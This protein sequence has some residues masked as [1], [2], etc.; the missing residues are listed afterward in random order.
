MMATKKLFG[1]KKA[2]PKTVKKA[3]LFGA[4]KAAPKKAPPKKKGGASKPGD[5]PQWY[6]SDRRLFLPGGL[7]EGGDYNPV[8]D[9][10]L[11]GDYGFDILNLATDKETLTKYRA[12]ELIHARWAMLGLVGVVVPEAIASAGVPLGESAVWYE[13]GKN[14]LDDGY[15]TWFGVKIPLPLPV[16]FALELALIAPAELY[17]GSQE[18]VIPGITLP[19]TGKADPL[20]PGKDF[21]FDPL[22]LG[23]DPFGL[24][25]GEDLAELKVKELKNG[26]LAMV[27]MLGVFVQAAV[28]HEGPYANWYKH[29]SNPFQYNLL[30]I[31]GNGSLADNQI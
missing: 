21:S 4:K 28:T 8:L 31:L 22:N 24:G 20:Y 18:N 6:G 23:L 11:P 16:I 1:A 10:S 9:G 27:A 15:Q 29:V 2:A 30:T 5:Y 26:R 14:V 7:L 17:R 25:G 3:P 13:A 12:A 19:F